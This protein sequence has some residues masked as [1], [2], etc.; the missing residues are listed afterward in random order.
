MWTLMLTC[1]C[2]NMLCYWFIINCIISYCGLIAEPCEPPCQN[3]IPPIISSSST[4][5]A[6]AS[7]SAAGGG[8]GATAST[9]GPGH[10]NPYDLR[11]KSPPS[12]HEAGGSSS[13]MLPARKRPRTS[14]H[15]ILSIEYCFI[16]HS[17]CWFRILNLQ[18]HITGGRCV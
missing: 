17:R 5:A 11:R 10:H 6:A 9:G 2:Y 13:C 16:F 12:H 1:L 8:A 15:W 14:V 4:V 3:N 18:I 7:S